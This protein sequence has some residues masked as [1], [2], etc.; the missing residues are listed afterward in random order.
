LRRARECGA[1]CVDDPIQPTDVLLFFFVIFPVWASSSFQYNR[2]LYLLLGSFKK[3]L[4]GI[5]VI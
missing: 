4:F 3:S 5:I 2:Q 1:A